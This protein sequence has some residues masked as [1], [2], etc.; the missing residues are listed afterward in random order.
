VTAEAAG[1]DERTLV[2]RMRTIFPAGIEETY[3]ERGRFEVAAYQSPPLTLPA[4]LGSWR[5][6]PVGEARV[7]SWQ[8]Q[9]HGVAIA[10]R[11]WVGPAAEPAP[12][13][14]LG[15]V[16]DARHAFGSGAHATTCGCLALLCELEPP[17]SVLDVGC[18]SGV[19]AI[20]AAKL[21]H[22]PV[23]AC[24][25]DPLATTIAS[26]N[27]AANGV[28]VDVFVADAAHDPLPDCDIWA[29]NLLGGPLSD[30]LARADAPPRAIVSG[31]L[32][33][34]HLDAPTYEIERRVTRAGWQ[35]LA[36]SR[37]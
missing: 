2:E 31:L 5:V 33:D 35:V 23:H 14:L 30:L 16:I 7:R 8:E 37:R 18:G 20:A 27:A 9:P 28:D 10:G 24:D 12:P 25:I 17:L 1:L 21:G 34:E 26:A 11:L 15:V 32:A 6:E 4:G 29:A 19:L 3:D 13:N 36:L 22:G